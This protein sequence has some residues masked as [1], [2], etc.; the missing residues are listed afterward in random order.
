MNNLLTLSLCRWLITK[1]ILISSFEHMGKCQ[2]EVYRTL[3]M[4]YKR[5]TGPKIN[6]YSLDSTPLRCHQEII[7]K[8]EENKK[9]ETKK[10]R[11]NSNYDLV[12]NTEIFFCFVFFFLFFYS[13]I[14]VF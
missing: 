11:K 14:S 1:G 8:T 6:D 13:Q 5:E 3:P 10:G 12:E 2:Y 4:L 9:R 7:Y